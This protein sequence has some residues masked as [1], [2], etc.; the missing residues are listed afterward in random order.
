MKFSGNGHKCKRHFM[1]KTK[2]IENVMKYKYLGIEFSSSGTWNHAISNLSDRGMK[3]LYLLKRY[4]SIGNIKPKLGLK[5]F[6]Q[7]IKPILCYCSEVWIVADLTKRNFNQSNG[8]AKFL[9]NLDIEKVHVRFIKFILGVNKKA[10]NLAVKDIQTSLT[11][12][13]ALFSKLI[14]YKCIKDIQSYC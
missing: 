10:V 14:V 2:T 3:A 11:L 1:Y 5:L 9:E 6:D 4:I 8:V 13:F 12:F 7:M